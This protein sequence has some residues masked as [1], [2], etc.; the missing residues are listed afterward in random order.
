MVTNVVKTK[1]GRWLYAQVVKAVKPCDPPRARTFENRPESS[2]HDTT[3]AV[4]ANIVNNCILGPIAYE[5]VSMNFMSPP[6]STG[7][8]VQMVFAIL[9]GHAIGY[10]SAHRWMHTR[11]MYWA[12]RSA[13]NPDPDPDHIA[14]TS[15]I[16]TNS[17]ARPDPASTHPVLHSPTC[18]AHVSPAPKQTPQVPPQ[19]QR[20]RGPRDCQRRESSGVLHSLRT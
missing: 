17:R 10:Y 20:L 11:E 12:H 8:R 16:C 4:L 6:L 3:Q 5:Y 9:A 14:S 18:A 19:I 2:H 13:S 1:S 15:P 7:G